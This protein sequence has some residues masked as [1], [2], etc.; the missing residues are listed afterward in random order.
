MKNQII[1]AATL[2]LSIIATSCGKHRVKGEG[3]S[4]SERRELA[5]FGSITAN[6]ST[7]ITV[8]PSNS[9]YVIVHGYN[10]LVPVYETRVSDG[11]LILE[12]KRDYINVKNNNITVDLY[13]TQAHRVT[14]NG[15]GDIKIE[16]GQHSEYMNLDING[17]GNI[18]IA[19]NHFKG[20]NADV[21]GSG[22]IKGIACLADTMKAHISG[23]GNISMS[24]ANYLEVKIS[25]SG[26]VDYW[27]QPVLGKVSISG[28]GK[29]HKH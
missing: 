6:G 25:G 14:L 5:T 28:S 8:H 4:T 7:N 22:N 12:F 2:A 1:L 9:D 26:D 3:S 20:V 10:N 18:T 19:N 17:S 27:G 29:V 15:S 24:V 11:R 13:T 16:D 21:N 23:S